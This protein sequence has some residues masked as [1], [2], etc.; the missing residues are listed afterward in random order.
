LAEEWQEKRKRLLAEKP[1]FLKWITD[2]FDFK[3]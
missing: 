3:I 1:N 2:T